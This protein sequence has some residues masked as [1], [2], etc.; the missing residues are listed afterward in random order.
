[1]FYS[2]VVL[3]LSGFSL[4]LFARSLISIIL[5]PLFSNLMCSIV[6]VVLVTSSIVGF[7]AARSALSKNLSIINLKQGC[8]LLLAGMALAMVTAFLNVL[9]ITQLHLVTNILNITAIVVSLAFF[10]LLLI[11]MS[12]RL[13]SGYEAYGS[14]ISICIAIFGMVSGWLII[15]K[16]AAFKSPVIGVA[17]SA[18]IMTVLGLTMVWP[19]CKTINKKVMLLF[20]TSCVTILSFF[21]I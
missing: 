16:Y 3:C 1:M 20:L 13:S 9:P 21:V 19:H 11:V 15:E 12:M 8:V 17:A 18:I 5:G 14:K 7:Y 6:I 2:L 4:G 10:P